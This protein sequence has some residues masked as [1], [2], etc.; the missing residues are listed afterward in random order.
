MTAPTTAVPRRRWRIAALLG[1]G[2]L[3]NYFDRLNLS[4][5]MPQ[6]RATFNLDAREA[7]IILGAF[8]WSYMLLQLPAGLL[9]DRYGTVRIGRW[10]AFL[11]GVASLVAALAGGLGGFIA[12]RLLLGAAEAPCFPM[13]AKATG[14]WF[15]RSER[16]LATALF[17]AAAKFSNVIGVP[18]VAA[19]VV[20]AGWR[21]GFGVTA[22]L[23]FAYFLVFYRTYSD[24]ASDR[25][26]DE[27][28]RAYI[29]AGGAVSEHAA[30]D[31]AL[32]MVGHLLRQPVL[33]GLMIGFAAYGYS[34]YLFLTWLPGYLVQSMHMSLLTSAGYA[35]IPWIVATLTDL[36][37]GGWLIDHLIVK[38]YSE[39]RVRMGVLLGGM[40]LGL[41]VFGAA[42]TSSANWA[43]LWISIAL[44]GL[45]AA[46]PVCWS[47]PALIAPPGAVASVGSLMNLA[48]NAMGGAAPIVTGYIVG[49]THSFDNAFIVAGAVLLI[50][51]ISF[52]LALH[53][54]LPIPDV[55]QSTARGSATHG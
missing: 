19:V 31:P 12:A 24:P 14:Y 17:D 7:G 26:L 32:R 23:S 54:M 49:A 39:A 18:L 51:I 20:W 42:W 46:A 16:G 50:G 4:V 55:D 1:A 2:V 27:R 34:F 11:W 9:L 38:G 21:W 41:A 44:G 22:A 52:I 40:A 48:N 13:C 25:S 53:S 45:A 10:G 3:I 30:R 47:L 43:I 33:W 6:L 28:E 37:V 5:A 29:I 8:F 15:P 35:A 36:L